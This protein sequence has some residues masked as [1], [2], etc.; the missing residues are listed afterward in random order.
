MVES[1]GVRLDRGIAMT[2]AF[3][4]DNAHAACH[5]KHHSTASQQTIQAATMHKHSQL[6]FSAI[7][8]S[9]HSAH[10]LLV[11]VHGDM[12]CGTSRGI[13][14]H[15]LGRKRGSQR[16][17]LL[18]NRG[19]RHNLTSWGRCCR[20]NLRLAGEDKPSSRCRSRGRG[21][22]VSTHGSLKTGVDSSGSGRLG[23]MGGTSRG[24]D[25]RGLGRLE[26]REAPVEE[27]VSEE[28]GVPVAGVAPVEP[29]TPEEG[30]VPDC[31]TAGVA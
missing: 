30:P 26:G 31:S 2:V 20:D 28:R 17:L 15:N 22:G 23:G 21:R 19:G 18:L 12:R 4:T 14:L 1:S 13:R 3:K 27:G 10:L 7:A 5:A 8:D 24:G 16:L 29:T 9:L 25:T 6:C 11:N